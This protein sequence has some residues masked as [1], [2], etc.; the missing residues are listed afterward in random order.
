MVLQLL[1]GIGMVAEQVPGVVDVEAQ[2]EIVLAGI[3]PRD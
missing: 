3:R 2:I 1:S